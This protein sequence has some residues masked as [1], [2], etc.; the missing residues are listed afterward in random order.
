MKINKSSGCDEIP[1]ELLKYA[2]EIVFEHIANI[3]N[4]LASNNECPKEINHGILIPLQKPGK[5]RG[6][7][8]NLR[9]IILLSVLRKILAVCIMNRIGERLDRETPITQAAYRKN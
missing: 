5:A 3:F 6:P 1:I 2:P 9:P 8:S 4:R 7:I